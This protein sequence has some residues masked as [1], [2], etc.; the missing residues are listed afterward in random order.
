MKRAIGLHSVLLLLLINT[1][2]SSLKAKDEVL[3]HLVIAQSQMLRGVTQVSAVVNKAVGV[4]G[5]L[6]IDLITVS[7][8]SKSHF[9]PVFI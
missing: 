3:R 1:L 2:L 6:V 5:I 4:G 8:V 9:K 7:P